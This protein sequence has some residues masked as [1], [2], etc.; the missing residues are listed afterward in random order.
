[1]CEYA[2]E[3]VPSLYAIEVRALLCAIEV[4]RSYV[5]LGLCASW[6]TGQEEASLSG[7]EALFG[8]CGDG[9]TEVVPALCANMR[10]KSCPPYMR[11]RFVLSYVR[12]RLCAPMCDWGCALH[13]SRGK[14]KQ[15]SQGLKPFLV[16]AV[17]ARL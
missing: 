8:L 11:L 16:C 17:T 13:G 3:V 14:K 12:L 9:T 4:V 10:L 2:I 15:V 1:M 7:A 6:F 5:R